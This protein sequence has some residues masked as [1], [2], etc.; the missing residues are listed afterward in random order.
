MR[1]LCLALAL[2]AGCASHLHVSDCAS[3]LGA[4]LVH[5]KVSDQQQSQEILT[6]VG[7]AMKKQNEAIGEAF[8]KASIAHVGS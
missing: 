6:A 5:D 8:K 7:D 3:C 1:A 2:L 4:V